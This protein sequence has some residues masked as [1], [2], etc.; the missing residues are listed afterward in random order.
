MGGS[1]AGV[2]DAGLLLLVEM[3]Q[4]MLLS[5]SGG[6]QRCATHTERMLLYM[7]HSL[8]RPFGEQP[9]L[10]PHRPNRPGCNTDGAVSRPRCVVLP[11]RHEQHEHGKEDANDAVEAQGGLIRLM[12]EV[13]KSGLTSQGKSYAG[14][15]HLGSAR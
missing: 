4:S 11:A 9:H 3:G 8:E 14:V 13:G 15:W 6:N 7:E 12:V 1:T 10:R 5:F 2:V